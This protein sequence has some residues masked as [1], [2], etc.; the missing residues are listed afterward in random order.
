M[1]SPGF[2]YQESSNEIDGKTRWEDGKIHRIGK[3]MVNK[4]Y[5]KK[6]PLFEKDLVSSSSRRISHKKGKQS[7]KNKKRSGKNGTRKMIGGANMNGKTFYIGIGIQQEKEGG[8][9]NF[10]LKDCILPSYSPEI[11]DT[12]RTFEILYGGGANEIDYQKQHMAIGSNI[13]NATFYDKI[14]E[15]LKSLPPAS[16]TP[17]EISQGNIQDVNKKIQ[18]NSEDVNNFNRY[19][20]QSSKNGNSNGNTNGN[21]N[22]SKKGNTNG[23]MNGST[24]GSTNA[25]S[26]SPSL[27]PSINKDSNPS[28]NIN[29]SPD[30]IDINTKIPTATAI[31]G[32]TAQNTNQNPNS[33]PPPP[34]GANNLPMADNL[35]SNNEPNISKEAIDSMKKD[36]KEKAKDIQLM[37]YFVENHYHNNQTVGGEL[38]EDDIIMSLALAIAA[39]INQTDVVNVPD[40]TPSSSSLPINGDAKTLKNAL[41]NSKNR[42]MELLKS[43]YSIDNVDEIKKI[44]DEVGTLH[45]KSKSILTE[46]CSK[47]GIS[48]SECNSSELVK[49]KVF[50][51]ET[52]EIIIGD[53]INN[54]KS[55]LE[56]ESLLVQLPFKIDEKIERIEKSRKEETEKI[57]KHV[58]SLNTL[59]NQYKEQNNSLIKWT[60]ILEEVHQYAL[61]QITNL[62]YDDF[63]EGK[64]GK[65]YEEKIKQIQ[66]VGAQLKTVETKL[67]SLITKYNDE[68]QNKTNAITQTNT[69]NLSKSVSLNPIKPTTEN[70]QFL[71]KVIDSKKKI[72]YETSNIEN[73]VDSLKNLSIQKIK[74]FKRKISL[75]FTSD[76]LVKIN[77]ALK[78]IKTYYQTIQIF[79][80]DFDENDKA[81]VDKLC[82][83]DECSE[84]KEIDTLIQDIDKNIKEIEEYIRHQGDPTIANFIEQYKPSR[85]PKLPS[86]TKIPSIPKFPSFKKT[87]KNTSDNKISKPDEVIEE[88]MNPL[89]QEQDNSGESN[90]SLQ[91]AGKRKRITQKIYRKR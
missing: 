4:R 30:N 56:L 19:L 37:N 31:P 9:L 17:M 14:I 21:T 77:N 75:V 55:I 24:N 49:I 84:F 3:A 89:N 45:E 35:E 34:S 8:K 22:G 62:T 70:P 29:K 33:P 36:I 13:D 82:I 67:L 61:T 51:D 10:H 86:I 43:L 15:N 90:P 32:S 16:S 83:S 6:T 50:D 63:K 40:N 44:Q 91:T 1:K 80:K 18:T 68:I 60:K 12:H 76:E 20:S 87:V 66:D 38:E 72:E 58:E 79:E 42:T 73:L 52:G 39:A 59:I 81:I 64:A 47:T 53:I 78:K 5:S 57:G 23:S 46:F 65:V 71:K 2:L 11:N 26:P 27:T 85:L 88:T 28:L 7:R 41:L 74:S 25:V 69:L 48:E 54:D